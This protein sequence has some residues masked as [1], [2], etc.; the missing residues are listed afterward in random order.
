MTSAH[1]LFAEFYTLATSEADA[2]EL[3]AR[4]QRL[5]EAPPPMTLTLLASHSRSNATASFSL[6]VTVSPDTARYNGVKVSGGEILA[7]G[8][9]NGLADTSADVLLRYY[10]AR[11]LH[12]LVS[13]APLAD[14]YQEAACALGGRAGG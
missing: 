8:L 2:G 9:R 13:D 11:G 7:R 14:G 6:E 1:T 5:Q 3:R 4:V 10:R 12:Y